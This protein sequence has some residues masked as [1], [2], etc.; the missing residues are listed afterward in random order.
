MQPEKYR[1]L[2]KTIGTQAEVAKLLGL[3]RLT[4]IRRESGNIAVTPEAAVAIRALSSPHNPARKNP[5]RLG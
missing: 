1:E 2:R 3:S 5:H 4:I